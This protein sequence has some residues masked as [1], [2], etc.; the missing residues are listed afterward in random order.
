MVRNLDPKTE[1]WTTR[2]NRR[3]EN[4]ILKRIKRK[5]PDLYE[6]KLSRYVGEKIAR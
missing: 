6:E 4:K 1:I 2:F 3:L 5:Y